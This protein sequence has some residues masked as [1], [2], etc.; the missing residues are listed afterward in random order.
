MNAATQVFVAITDELLY[1]NPESIDNPLVP[2]T[3]NMMCHHWLDIEI[4][5]D[6][7]S[8]SNVSDSNLDNS[9]N[10]QFSL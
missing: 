2:Y 5:P 7:V 10:G 1:E 9:M 3:S 4:N 6:D 8:P